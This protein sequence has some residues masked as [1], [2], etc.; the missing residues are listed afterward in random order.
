MRFLRLTDRPLSS[1]AEA[2][3]QFDMD[4]L[5]QVAQ[6]KTGVLPELWLADPDL[7]EKDGRVLT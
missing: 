7:Y 3:I 5:R 2:L 4:S 1:K 6:A